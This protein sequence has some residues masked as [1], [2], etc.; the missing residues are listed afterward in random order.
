ML[1]PISDN[2]FLAKD[3]FKRALLYGSNRE[4]ML[5]GELLN[6]TRVE[7]GRLISGPFPI[8]VGGADPLS[9]AYDPE[10]IPTGYNPQLAKLLF[11]MTQRELDAIPPVLEKLRVACPDF[12]FARVAV[13][14][15]IQQW[16]IVGIKAEMVILPAGKSYDVNT[17][18]DLLYVTATLWEPAT[19]IERLLGASG[20]AATDNPFIVLGL[21]KL[22][23]ARNWKEVRTS[24]QDLHRLIDYHLP[25]LP[26]WQITDRFAA[27]RYVEGLEDAPVSLYENVGQWRINLGFLETASN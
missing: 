4:G 22:R 3:K 8:G 9:Y 15:L 25:I 16:S 18:C 7:D 13:Q 27:S 2:P 10:V 12:E 21:E 23:G 26:L 5:N 20:L 19:D 6:S 17:P 14:A 11:V 24:L 1:V